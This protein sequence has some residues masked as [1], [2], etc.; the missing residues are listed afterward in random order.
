MKKIFLLAFLFISVC[1]IAQDVTIEEDPQPTAITK[2]SLTISWTTNIDATSELKWGYTSAL[3]QTAVKKSG[4]TQNHSVLLEGLNASELIYVMAY[5]VSGSDT[6]KSDVQLN[7]TASESTGSVKVYFNATVDHSVATTENAIYVD[8]A[9]ADTLVNY[10]GRAKETIDMAIYNL[11][12]Y[13]NSQIVN[14]LNSAYQRGVIVRVVYNGSTTNSG[15]GSLNSNI[16]K[17]ES[18][19]GASEGIMHNKFLVFDV[20]SANADDAIV[21][22]G[23]TNFTTGQLNTDPNDVIIIND[24]SLAKAYTIEFN[25]MFGSDGASPSESNAKFGAEKED[26]TP[27]VFNVGGTRIESYFSPS[28][29]AHDKIIETIEKAENILSIATMLVT[30]EDIAKAV[31]DASNDNVEV[32]M[33]IDDI[34]TYSQDAILVSAL[35]SD[36]RTMGEAGIM[37]HKYMIADHAGSDEGAKVLTGCHNWSSSAKDRNDENTLIVRDERVANLYYQEFANRFTNGEIVAVQPIC[38]PDTSEFTKDD[39]IIYIDI[40]ANDTLD[41]MVVVDITEDTDLGIVYLTADNR[42]SYRPKLGFDEGVDSIWYSVCAKEYGAL[43]DEALV[44]VKVNLKEQTK[45]NQNL[46]GIAEVYPTLGGGVFTINGIESN[47]SVSIINANGQVVFEEKGIEA[48]SPYS[49]DISH[50][51]KGIYYMVISSAEGGYFTQTIILTE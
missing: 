16:G 39:E 13:N 48:S 29:N 21:W 28:D 23:S 51:P 46:Q 30:R 24:R 8:D 10:I 22:T 17:I 43:C 3:E 45:L 31:R 18:P 50:H 19:T 7:I 5:S 47:Y 15:I 32:E 9:I 4:A 33:I 14:A 26:N 2:T 35:G 38:L 37:H 42:L 40:L 25:E 1:V 27:H 41:G 36:F 6:A 44:T 11:D 49:F 12:K 20:N 34:D